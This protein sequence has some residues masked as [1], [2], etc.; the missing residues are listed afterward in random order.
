MRVATRPPRPFSPLV[1]AILAV[2]ALLVGVAGTGMAVN[3]YYPVWGAMNYS[4]YFNSGTFCQAQ[5]QRVATDSSGNVFAAISAG[6]GSSGGGG[7]GNT[8]N[9]AKISSSGKILWQRDI[10]NTSLNNITVE[11]LATDASGN[12]YVGGGF[13]NG[14]NSVYVR[15]VSA[16]GS[17]LW[18]W[19]KN[20]TSGH[21]IAVDGSGVYVGTDNSIY[22]ID[23]SGSATPLFTIN[24]TPYSVNSLYS[25]GGGGYL[26]ASFA[27][28]TCG[29]TSVQTYSSSTG[30]NTGTSSPSGGGGRIF[31]APDGRVY[32]APAPPFG[33]TT[34]YGG[35]L[36]KLTTGLVV[37]RQ[38]TVDIDLANSS[39]SYQITPQD[40]GWLPSGELVCVWNRVSQA[41]SGPTIPTTIS[42]GVTALKSTFPPACTG[43]GSCESPAIWSQTAFTQFYSNS[44]GTSA[45][46]NANGLAVGSDGKVYLATGSQITGGPGGCSHYGVIALDN[47]LASNPPKKGEMQIR[48]NVIRAGQ[49]GTALIV[50]Q[51]AP[52]GNVNLSIFGPSG[53][54]ITILQQ[55]EQ[56]CSN[57]GNNS[58]IQL[59]DAG[60]ATIEFDGTYDGTNPLGYGLYWIVA[61]G[62]ISARKP[63]VIAKPK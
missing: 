4:A 56:G 45:S 62:D 7:T 41:A 24:P 18:L 26:Y 55:A 43:G 39:G 46:V 53:N 23:L 57:C 42:I 38:E 28:N 63:I 40:L 47:A 21:A 27:M 9:I 50:L 32:V 49:G 12:L 6:V 59:D 35:Y 58:G 51:G 22:K 34:C 17:D 36:D 1:I 54:L 33:F 16:S 13:N 52:H 44:S 25:D 60:Q 20:D 3:P 15:A 14:V 61:G 29:S 30:V 2:G 37:D 8:I 31:H 5:V 11:G 10:T 48:R 19:S